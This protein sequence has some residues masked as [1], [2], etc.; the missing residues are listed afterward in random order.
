MTKNS[1]RKANSIW[2]KTQTPTIANTT[3]NLFLPCTRSN[4]PRKLNCVIEKSAASAAC[5]PSCNQS[6]SM[7]TFL[8]PITIYVYLPTSN[9][10]KCLPSSNP[11]CNQSKSMFTFLQPITIY[12]YL[13]T[14]NHNKCLLPYNQ[15]LSMPTLIQPIAINVFLPTTNYNQQYISQLRN[16]SDKFILSIILQKIVF[17]N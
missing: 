17:Y 16:I 9:H 6:Q 8:Q 10:N 7:F 1:A 2:A 15:T 14:S 12:V 5:L 13:P 3:T 11:S 4:R